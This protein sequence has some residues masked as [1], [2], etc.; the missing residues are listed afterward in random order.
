MDISRA[1]NYIPLASNRFITALAIYLCFLELNNTRRAFI[2]ARS[3]SLPSAV[4]EGRYKS[5]HLPLRLCSCHLGEIDTIEHIL[6]NCPYYRE[7]WQESA[8]PL[9]ERFPRRSSRI[10]IDYLLANRNYQTTHQV[11]KFCMQV[12]KHWKLFKAV[13]SCHKFKYFT[14]ILLLFHLFYCKESF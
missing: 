12:Y 2:L 6:L 8:G 14:V 10:K 13:W 7:I 1:P 4:M 11:V 5:V 3:L 9:L